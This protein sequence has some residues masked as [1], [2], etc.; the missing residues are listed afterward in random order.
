MGLTG[1]QIFKLLPK[2]NCKECGVATCMAFAM[3]LANSK[4]SLDQCP[5]VSDEA[6]EQLDAAA[7][8]PIKKVTLGAGDFVRTMGDETELFRHDKKFFNET[9]IAIMVDDTEDV[10]AKA[11]SFD[12]KVYERVGLTFYTDA[13]AIIN[14]SGDAGKFKAA[15]EAAM[16][17]TNR[18]LVLCSEDADAMAAAVEAAADRKPLICSATAANFDKMVELAVSKGCPLS[19]KGANLEEAVELA[20][21]AAAAGA[22]EVVIDSGSRQVS[23]TV[24]DLTQL[25]RQ[26]L[27]R[28]KGFGFPA[29]AVVTAEDPMDQV[30]EAVS[31]MSN[32]AGLIAL[33]ADDDALLLP[34]MAW[35]Q[36]LYTD[37]QKPIAVEPGLKEIGDVTPDSPVYTTTNFSL[38]YY[39]VEGEVEASKVPSYILSVDTDGISVLTG[40]AAGKFTGDTIAAAIKET[41]LEEKVNHKNIVIPGG[42]AVISGK[43]EDAS[44]WKA[45]V[46]PR[47]AS[48]I[49]KFVR[50]NFAK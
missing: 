30:V 8:P 12:K 16:G 11:E 6:K 25:R 24:A 15:V 13:L 21:K 34:L 22:K 49:P 26:A 35:R 41:G 43:L 33:K 40:F 47:E 29:M 3:A 46:G 10:A 44:G 18:V 27:K 42:V 45:M 36:N 39:I 5:Y 28:T 19:V 50:E 17:K 4:A 23:Q 38:T 1:L 14:A 48:G 37:P 31:Y 2:T 9:V 32:Y 20:T 7:A